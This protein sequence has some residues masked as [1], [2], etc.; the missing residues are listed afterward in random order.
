MCTFVVVSPRIKEEEKKEGSQR[1]FFSFFSL[2]L[3]LDGF[4][5]FFFLSFVISFWG[6][7]SFG[8]PFFCQLLFQLSNPSWCGAPSEGF[9]FVFS[10]SGKA[11]HSKFSPQHFLFQFFLVVIVFKCFA[12]LFSWES[13]FVSS[14]SFEDSGLYFTPDSSF[15][16]EEHL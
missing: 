13:R 12:L 8:I 9:R 7:C 11:K 2:L 6:L 3:Q 14:C 16:T 10:H 1:I 5:F 15:S 4:P